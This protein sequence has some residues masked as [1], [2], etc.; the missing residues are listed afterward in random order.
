MVEVHAPRYG[1]INMP[2]I[3]TWPSKPMDEP[4]WALNLMH[5][6]T[7]AEYADG[8]ETDLTGW[9]ADNLYSPLGPLAA[10][11]AELVIVAIV[12]DQPAGS[13][14]KWDRVAIVRYPNRQALADMNMTPEFQEAHIHKD[15]G[16]KFTIVSATF[17]QPDTI[18]R[19]LI[20][21]DTTYEQQML[22]QVV[23]DADAPE[24]Q[25]PGATRIAT[26]TVE[27]NVIGDDRKWA[28]ARWDLVPATVS[29]ETVRAATEAAATDGDRYV[30]LLKPQLGDFLRA[31]AKS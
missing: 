10:I 18:D 27:D 3:A 29:A 20:D 16:M 24:V 15:A 8:R 5:Y 9:E 1:T 22:L 11:G 2:Y 31:V 7:K 25:I 14:Y 13:D 12:V 28:E 21:T 26:F 23:A 4:M 19:S 17:P 6:R 30:L